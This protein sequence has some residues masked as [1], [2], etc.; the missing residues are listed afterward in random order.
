MQP[1]WVRKT[2]KND[3][4]CWQTVLTWKGCRKALD[5]KLNRGSELRNATNKFAIRGKQV[6]RRRSTNQKLENWRGWAVLPDIFFVPWLRSPVLKCMFVAYCDSY[7]SWAPRKMKTKTNGNKRKNQS[8]SC[9][10]TRRASSRI[11]SL[12]RSPFHPSQNRP[13]LFTEWEIMLDTI[14]NEC[15]SFSDNLKGRGIT[16]DKFV[17][18]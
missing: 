7:A 15:I 8:K 14:F 6:T 9:Y 4:V 11:P 17:L 16:S 2:Q 12:G 18:S 1:K 5:L 10:I 3:M 13:C